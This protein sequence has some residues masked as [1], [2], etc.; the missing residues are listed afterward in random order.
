MGTD[1]DFSDYLV[2]LAKEVRDQESSQEQTPKVIVVTRAKAKEE[3]A[4][5]VH[6]QQLNVQD[7]ATPP[8]LETVPISPTPSQEE[9]DRE[10]NSE[11]G[12]VVD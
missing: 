4:K 3:V 8:P 12:E 1:L 2:K 5:E 9:S 11:T 6:D 10:L 7:Q